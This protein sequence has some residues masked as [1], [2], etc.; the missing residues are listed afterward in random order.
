MEKFASVIQ[1]LFAAGML[2]WASYMSIRLTLEGY[3]TFY[4]AV[5]GLIAMFG[6]VLLRLSIKELKGGRK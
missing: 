3:D 2:V 5:F 4:T 6:G 1:T